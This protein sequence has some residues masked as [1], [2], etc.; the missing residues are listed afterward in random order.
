MT[1]IS[2]YG[3]IKEIKRRI[4][5]LSNSLINLAEILDNKELADTMKDEAER[6]A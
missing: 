6:Q 1:E 3:N 2:K 4:V 5:A